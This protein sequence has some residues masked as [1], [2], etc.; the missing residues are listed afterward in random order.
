MTAQ[1]AARAIPWL[2]ALGVALRLQGLGWDGGAGLHPDERNL[3]V[4]AAALRFPGGLIP[5]F[6]AY[7]G[8]A[9]LLPKALAVLACGPEP[10]LPCVTW[11]ARL[12]SALCAAGALALAARIAHRLGGPVA[13]ALALVL[14][15]LSAPLVQWAHFGTT[16]S[17]LTLAVLALWWLAIR[18]LDG[19]D[20]VWRAALGSGAVLGLAMGTK[21]T[22]AAFALIPLA[23]LLLGRG[24][25][26]QAA[27]AAV[28]AAALLALALLLLTTPALV[29]ATRDY[30][31]VMRFEGDV[32]AGR[33]DVFWTWQFEGARPGLFEASQLWRMMDGTGLLLAGAGLLWGWRRGGAALWVAMPF[34][35]LY[36]A[37]ILGW[38]ARF[39]RYLAPALPILLVLAALGAAWAWEGLRGRTARVALVLA[40]LPPAAAG[41]STALS[42]R[43]PDSRLL[44]AQDLR[45]RL[46]PGDLVLLEPRDVGPAAF[47]G[48]ETRVLPLT[49]PSGGEKLD[50]L[51]RDL[52]EGDW[53][54]IYSRRHWAVLPRLA[55]FPEMCGYY[56]A[57]AGGTLG[58]EVVARFRRAAPLGPLLD[59]DLGSEETREVFDRPLVHL[60]QNTGRLGAG[61]I[62]ARIE[63]GGQGCAPEA[64]RDALARPR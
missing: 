44:A 15:G 62:R 4:G 25:L 46:A 47:E 27:V 53:M 55:R 32:V 40:L 51:A 5:E 24:R 48:V 41:L 22:A 58:W 39:T 30:L 59:P 18:F 23:A 63:G 34:A 45:A 50:A 64:I 31:G 7:N 20:G 3:A 21:T 33:A 11:A 26:G 54:L 38:H 28:P 6:H 2:L 29:V 16:E 19:R 52:A 12:V 35:V 8:L 49:E 43:S 42:F 17:A 13:A 10:G 9:L 1:G 60:L 57:L 37:T 56:A 61:E 36:M 14:A